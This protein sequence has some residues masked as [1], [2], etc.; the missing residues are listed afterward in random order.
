M[1]LVWLVLWLHV[2]LG[3]D[4]IILNVGMGSGA[5][6]KR[7]PHVSVV[8]AC[9]HA[10]VAPVFSMAEHDFEITGEYEMN[11]AFTGTGGF[12]A[13]AP[14]FGLFPQNTAVEFEPLSSGLPSAEHDHGLPLLV[15]NAK[16]SR[17]AMSISTPSL[18]E[19]YD[20]A[21][22]VPDVV[23]IG[24]SRSATAVA[25]VDA[26]TVHELSKVQ[27]ALVQEGRAIDELIV[28]LEAYST[29]LHRFGSDWLRFGPEDTILAMR[30]AATA[31]LHIG[32]NRHG[33]RARA[34]IIDWEAT[35]LE[36][37]GPLRAFAAS[38]CW[39]I[40]IE[41]IGNGRFAMVPCTLR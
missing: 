38:D 29:A 18:E 3:A 36:Y 31:L 4:A 20:A 11:W 37:L 16:N 13:P 8:A 24:S 5:S 19:P 33:T 15:Y 7:Q 34:W 23:A 40:G 10:L 22:P 32:V 21:P 6:I 25:H 14:E 17:V 26:E 1:L 9:D 30:I 2:F 39:G 41:D 28:K 35:Y 27:E 12:C